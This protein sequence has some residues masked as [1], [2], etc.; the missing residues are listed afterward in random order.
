MSEAGR[1]LEAT[2]VIGANPVNANE[3]VYFVSKAAWA[4]I[5]RLARPRRGTERLALVLAPVPGAADFLF[6]AAQG[7]PPRNPGQRPA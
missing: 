7:A 5:D 3:D 4:L 6:S 1:R 2:D